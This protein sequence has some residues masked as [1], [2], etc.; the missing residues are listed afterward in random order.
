MPFRKLRQLGKDLRRRVDGGLKRLSGEIDIETLKLTEDLMRETPV[1]TS[2]ALS[3]W[4]VS[5][6]FTP[7]TQIN[8]NVF[9]FQGSSREAS[10]QVGLAKIRFT[11]ANRGFLDTIVV[12]NNLDYL[13]RLNDGS[14]PQASSG[15]VEDVISRHKI[16]EN[17]VIKYP[18]SRL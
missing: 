9:G 2:K 11:L 16:A 17:L 6:N 13:E 12:F 3:N 1:D 4:R 10:I 18:R 8:A 5:L 14:S 7:P 15:F